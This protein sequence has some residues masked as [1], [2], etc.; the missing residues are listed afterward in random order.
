MEVIECDRCKKRIGEKAGD[1]KIGKAKVDGKDK[2]LCV[3]CTEKLGRFM[4]G[5]GDLRDGPRQGVSSSTIEAALQPFVGELLRADELGKVA[6]AVI[7]AL[8][9]GGAF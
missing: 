1:L 6:E 4:Q 8:P 9:N 2:V 3:D 5:D 7:A